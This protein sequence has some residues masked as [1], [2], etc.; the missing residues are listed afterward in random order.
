MVRPDAT[1]RSASRILLALPSLANS[2]RCLIRS[3]LVL[4]PPVRLL[5]M[6]T[7]T[8]L[9]CSLSPC[10][11]NSRS[12]FLYPAFGSSDSQYPRSHSCTV[13]PPYCPFAMLPS[14][15]PESCG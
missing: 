12:P 8:Q 3:Q 13:P 1:D 6:R 9:P 2:S 7:S 15:P 5:R 4:F 11:V 10:S 14:K